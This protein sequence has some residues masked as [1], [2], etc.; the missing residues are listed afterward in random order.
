MRL[1]LIAI[2]TIAATACAPRG[3]ITLFAGAG[4][5]G[6]VQRIY[7]G[8]TRE[9]DAVSGQPT[10]E[11][12]ENMLFGRVDVSVPP[13]RETGSVVFPGRKDPDPNLHFLV[14][15]FTPFA[16]AD[17]FSNSLR[18]SLS[19]RRGE[20]RVA[21]IFVHGFNNTFSEGLYRFA[22]MLEDLDLPFLPVH[23]TWP[24]AAHP[25]GYG[26]DRDSMLFARDGLERLMEA[27][28]RAGVNEVILVG[29]SMGALLTMES[30][31]QLAIG[32]K[33]SVMS[34]IGG[35]MLMSPDIDIDLFR[36]QAKR[37]GKLPQ[38]FYIFSSTR[39]RALRLSAGLTGQSARLGN[40]EDIAP[41]ADLD[42]T[43]VDLSAFSDGGLEH[44][45]ALSSP[46]F[47]R[48]LQ[49]VPDLSSAYGEDPQPG[50]LPG[51]V[52]VVQNA[53][54]LVIGNPN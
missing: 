37:I 28:T 10:G 45:V 34:R 25:L 9:I 39:D 16:N 36:Q 50:L 21:V 19:G 41:L 29:H 44:S 51:T 11:R 35:V 5:V 31:R 3:K 12:G 52:L 26:Y 13:D 1:I 14:D 38:P 48:L 4:D 18:K 22:Q 7:V 23:Y 54:K 46:G 49:S 20:E 17:Q 33:S 53:T 43:L 15:D 8:S 27:T 47:L 32:R 30:L 2:V 42:V 24:S 6:E 40:A